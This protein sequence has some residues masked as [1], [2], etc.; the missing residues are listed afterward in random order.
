MDKNIIEM[1]VPETIWIRKSKTGKG[2]SFGVKDIE[3]NWTNYIAAISVVED[4]LKDSKK[5]AVAF[6]T[7]EAVE[8]NKKSTKEE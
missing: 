3:G 4:F 1:E 5:Q 8:K 6:N 2:L 7:P